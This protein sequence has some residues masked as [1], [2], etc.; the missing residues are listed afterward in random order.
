MLDIMRPGC[1]WPR[2]DLKERMIYMWNGLG[3]TYF[4]KGSNTF[5]KLMPH[6]ML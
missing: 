3:T 2:S 6:K 1:E 5:F 4:K